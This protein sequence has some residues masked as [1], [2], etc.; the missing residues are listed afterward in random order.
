MTFPDSDAYD[1][2]SLHRGS[3]E[4]LT[5][6]FLWTGSVHDETRR[7]PELRGPHSTSILDHHSKENQIK[8]CRSFLNTKYVQK[9]CRVQIEG[10]YHHC[11]PK[12]PAI[13][14]V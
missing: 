1:S 9:D 3:G 4:E 6:P 13:L 14:I 2:I 7:R 12:H 8:S 11:L 10:I 5:C